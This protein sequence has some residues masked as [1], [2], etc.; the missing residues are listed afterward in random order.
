MRLYNTDQG[1][2]SEDG[3]GGPHSRRICPDLGE[4]FARRL[5][6]YRVRTLRD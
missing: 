5:D 6:R 3:P 4:W 2:R 1:L